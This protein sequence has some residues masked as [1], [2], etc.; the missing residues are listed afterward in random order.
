MRLS[1]KYGGLQFFAVP[2]PGRID[3]VVNGSNVTIN[4]NPTAANNTFAAAAS[5]NSK[6]YTINSNNQVVWYDGKFLA[7]NNVIV[8]GSDQIVSNRSYTTVGASTMS[9]SYNLSTSTKWASLSDGEHTVKIKAKGA[10]YGSSSFSNSVTVT[11][12]T[13]ISKNWKFNGTAAAFPQKTVQTY[14]VISGKVYKDS[15]EVEA[16]TRIYYNSDWTYIAFGQGGFW[17][18][19]DNTWGKYGGNILKFDTEPDG[20]LLSFLQAHAEP[21]A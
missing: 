10:G 17:D 14:D 4:I 15:T 3:I 1:N 8:L 6:T 16:F 19:S 5:N 12:G 9:K 13:V 11:K 7:Y 2:D 20:A 18:T 21:I